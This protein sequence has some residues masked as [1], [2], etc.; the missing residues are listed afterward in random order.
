MFVRSLRIKTY[1]MVESKY[2]ES[3]E[4]TEKILRSSFATLFVAVVSAT[5]VVGAHA[6]STPTFTKDVAP[7]F[8]ANCA[9]CHRPG[10]IAPMSL[11][12]YEEARPWAKSI[13]K[14]VAAREMPPW[15]ANPKHG[16]FS[17]DMS[18]TQVE[19]DTIVGWVDAGAPR[20]KRTDLPK[21]PEFT[22]GWRN[23]EPDYI[24]ELEAIEVAADEPDFFPN[25]EVQVD[26]PED[27]WIQAI[28]FRPG[29]RQVLHHV[30]TFLGGGTTT[31]TSLPDFLAV[32]APGT[33][34]AVYPEGMG[35]KIGKNAT[36]T[37]NMHYHSYGEAATDRTRVGLYFTDKEPEKAINGQFA[38]T[39]NFRIPAN[40]NDYQVDARYVV[41]ED[42]Q[43]IS[44]FP[45]MHT[46]GKSMKYTATYP[47]GRS[48]ILLDV[49]K[50]DFNWQWY[51]YPE[52][53]ITLPEGTVLDIEAHYDNSSDNPN[54]PDPSMDV[55]FGEGT[56]SEM[57]F[58]VFD[59]IPVDGKYPKPIDITK[60]LHRVLATY[61][62]ETAFQV[63]VDLGMMKLKSGFIVPK[64]GDGIWYLPFGRQLFELPLSNIQWTGNAFHADI[65]LL[66]KS[67][68]T[69]DGIVSAD[70]SIEGSFDIGEFDASDIGGLNPEGFSGSRF[71][72]KVARQ[73]SD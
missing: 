65:T 21:V 44:F 66:G 42:I 12:T 33:P 72:K 41:D 47:D 38:G 10:E 62:S 24:I 34:P 59:F 23:G 31:A 57:M 22:D 54:N 40:D 46:R 26:L 27:K 30:V 43:L 49:A 8:Y 6:R 17:N 2:W 63:S 37:M 20:G 7:I 35:R 60:K 45:H 3:K 15:K 39:V 19:I 69:M 61:D 73:S 28:E 48:E 58:G 32:W 51:Y 13:A 50:Y 71:A 4:M 70:G 18:L 53:P 5:V 67:G 11:L 36:I 55:I 68:I 9:E 64:E 25:I 52:E 16:T 1:G 14:N 29:N 56:E